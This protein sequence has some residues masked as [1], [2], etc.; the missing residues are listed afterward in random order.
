MTA[1]HKDLIAGVIATLVGAGVVVGY[2]S[3][4]SR[5]FKYCLSGGVLRIRMLGFTMRRIQVSAIDKIQII[6][7]LDTIPFTRSFRPHFL[8]AQRWGG[9]KAKEIA[10]E[11]RRGLFKRLIIS[12]KEPDA[13][14]R[15]LQ[16]ECGRPL[17]G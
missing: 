5:L 16:A 9:C 2:I 11:M 17:S 7:C 8:L 10:L 15:E 12:P 14:V 1:G 6:N 3:A 4:L 13:F